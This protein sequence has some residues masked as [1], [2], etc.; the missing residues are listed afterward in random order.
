MCISFDQLLKVDLKKYYMAAW[1]GGESEGK[2]IHAYV[3]LSP[4]AIHLRPS[5]HC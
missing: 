5:Q 3:W 2:W 1:M 4:F